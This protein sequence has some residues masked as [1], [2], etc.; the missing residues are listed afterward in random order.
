VLA[1]CALT[2]A[3]AVV[4]SALRGANLA[5]EANPLMQAA[6]SCRRRRSWPPSGRWSGAPRSCWRACAATSPS[7]YQVAFL[8]NLLLRWANELS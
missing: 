1:L 3:A 2:L 7:S 4:T 5:G 6:W 8:G